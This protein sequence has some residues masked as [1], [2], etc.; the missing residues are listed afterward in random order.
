L[1]LWARPAGTSKIRVWSLEDKQTRFKGAAAYNG[2]TDELLSDVEDDGEERETNEG[3]KGDGGEER[4]MVSRDKQ[5]K[6]GEH[7]IRHLKRDGWREEERQEVV[8]WFE[9]GTLGEVA[10]GTSCRR[11][12]PLLRTTCA[13]V[14]TASQLYRSYSVRREYIRDCACGTRGFV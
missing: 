13:I 8:C 1:G 3:E 6:V 9:M 7:A 5:G 14:R 4:K 11:L 10:S 2:C 12:V